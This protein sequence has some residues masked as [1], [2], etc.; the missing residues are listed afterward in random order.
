M[1]MFLGRRTSQRPLAKEPFLRILPVIAVSA[2]F[3]FFLSCNGGKKD[4]PSSTAA[5][6]FVYGGDVYVA[7]SRWDPSQNKTVA[8]VWKSGAPQH[9]ATQA[10][11]SEG[12]SVFVANGDVYVAGVQILSP[13]SDRPPGYGP[14]GYA[15][16]WKNGTPQ[17]L[18]NE[19]FGTAANSVFVSGG[20]V[21]VAGHFVDEDGAH[22]IAMKNGILMPYAYR[23]KDIGRSIFVSNGDVYVAGSTLPPGWVGYSMGALWKNGMFVKPTP[24][25]GD[26][27]NQY[28]RFSW[29]A[30]CVYV[31]GE[32]VYVVGNFIRNSH[33]SPVVWIN[34][35]NIP[36]PHFSGGAA[37]GIGS[38]FATDEDYYLAGYCQQHSSETLGDMFAIIQK[39][40]T[41]IPT[42]R[43]PSKSRWARANSVFVSGSDVYAAGEELYEPYL[44]HDPYY[45]ST[46][47]FRKSIATLWKNGVPQELK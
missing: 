45:N 11:G 4:V 28:D 5:S 21:Y 24:E 34:E 47:V 9:L 23:D 2:I 6:I 37:N 41:L 31:I 46:L 18:G 35:P 38:V 1:E 8:T 12:H 14:V 32:T 15:T 10:I 22:S 29:S 42:P 3:A 39:N 27:P 13:A 43:L 19:V 7:G 36:L 16:L 25:Y 26:Q 30:D 40:D 44:Y 33:R 20:D 17:R